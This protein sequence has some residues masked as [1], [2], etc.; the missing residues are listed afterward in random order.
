MTLRL[1]YLRDFYAKHQTNFGQPEDTPRS[2]V[3][4]AAL[5]EF[6]GL[7]QQLR[8]EAWDEGYDA[9]ADDTLFDQ[10]GIG[11]HTYATNPYEAETA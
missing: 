8:S 6:D 10:R 7:I 9:G 4:E 1:D 11:D 5:R 2:T 3:R